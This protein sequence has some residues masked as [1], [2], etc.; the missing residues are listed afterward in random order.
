MTR[1]RIPGALLAAALA[2]SAAADV[3]PVQQSPTIDGNVADWSQVLLNPANSAWDGEG[4]AVQCQYSTDRDCA[5]TGGQHDL[6]RFA[7]TWDAT[8]FYVLL[9]RF[10]AGAPWAYFVV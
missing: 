7:W 1:A 3:I 2:V 10:S 8:R 5:V 6:S 9:E 4:A